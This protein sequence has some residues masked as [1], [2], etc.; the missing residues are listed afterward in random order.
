M[1]GFPPKVAFVLAN[2]L[3]MTS[4]SFNYCDLNLIEIAKLYFTVL[5]FV[6]HKKTGTR[7]LA[8]TQY[9]TDSAFSF[10]KQSANLSCLQGSS[11]FK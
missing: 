7:R 5:T 3:M 8:R 11:V 1:N 10:C 6:S 9:C 4:F 2:R